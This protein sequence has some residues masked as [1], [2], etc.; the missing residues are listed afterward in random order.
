MAITTLIDKQDNFEVIRDQIASILVIEIANQMQLAFDAG[1]VADDWKL[2][3]FTERANPWEQ[4]LNDQTDRSPIIN[5]WYDNSN[6][7]MH[8]SNILERQASETVY[9]IDC[10]GYGMSEDDIGPGSHPRR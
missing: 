8:K 1:K 10:Y 6:F 4:W 3:I 2:R 9:N 7:A 5:V